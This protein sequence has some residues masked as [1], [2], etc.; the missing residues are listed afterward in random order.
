MSSNMNDEKIAG[1]LSSPEAQAKVEDPSTLG[2]IQ[3]GFEGAFGMVKDKLGSSWQDVRTLYQMAFDKDFQMDG[4]V[5]I[6]VIG[7]LAYLVSPVDLLPER[8][9]KGLGFADDVVVLLFALKYAQPE[10]E[11]YRRFKAGAGQPKPQG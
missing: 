5:K 7:A 2:G 11:R 10:I 3:S 4:K 8:V 1:M 6:V 9:F